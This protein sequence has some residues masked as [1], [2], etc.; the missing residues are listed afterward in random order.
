MKKSNTV[1]LRAYSRGLDI[2]HT[3]VSH[4]IKNGK[5]NKGVQYVTKIRKGVEVQVPVINKIIADIEFGNLHKTDKLKPGQ[6]KAGK[7]LKISGDAIA[8][9]LDGKKNKGLPL[10]TSDEDADEEHL[11]SKMHIDKQMSYG[12]ASRRRELIGLAMDK[13]KLQELEGSLV[14][15]D[16][17][18]KAL[19][20]IGSELKKALFNV[21]ARITADV[22]AAAND[23]YAQ[24][25]ITV[26]LTQILN[27]FSKKTEI[28]I[29]PAKS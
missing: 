20:M 8:K 26:E 21:P 2:S 17:I 18:E 22:R 3:A 28:E 16:V 27:E 5:I 4:A 1:S 13:K 15:K 29:K 10:I 6:T 24:S 19:F 25:I 11:L 9:K 23:V 7:L 12:E 14:R